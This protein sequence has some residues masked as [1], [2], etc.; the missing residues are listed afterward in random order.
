MTNVILL[1]ALIG[2]AAVIGWAAYG[3]QRGKR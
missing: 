2:C 1:G 3:T